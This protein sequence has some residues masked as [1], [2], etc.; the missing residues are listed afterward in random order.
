MA[1]VPFADLR[2]A[3]EMAQQ[4]RTEELIERAK[5]MRPLDLCD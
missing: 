2:S 5:G 4:T 1:G 3:Y